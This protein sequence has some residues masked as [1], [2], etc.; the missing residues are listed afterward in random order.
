[1]VST[2][3]YNG[4]GQRM[5][6]T[7]EGVTT[8]Y[9][10][11]VADGLPEVIIATIGG[12]SMYYVQIQGQVLAQQETGAWAY[13]LPD[14]LGSVRQLVDSEGQV[15]LAQSYDPFGVPFEASGSGES[16]FGYTGEAW[17][18]YNELL[19]LRARYY[20]PMVGRLLSKDIFPG[21]PKSPQSLNG[22]SYV[23]NNPIKHTD[24]SGLIYIDGWGYT[25]DDPA[26]VNGL[27][28]DGNPCMPASPGATLQALSLCPPLYAG[29][30]SWKSRPQCNYVSYSTSPNLVKANL[31][32]RETPP[33]PPN[34]CN[35][36]STSD[37]LPLDAIGWRADLSVGF[38]AAGDINVDVI[39]NVDQQL[40][41][42]GPRGWE[43]I[44][45]DLGVYFSLGGQGATVG[46]GLSTGPLF[47]FNLP[48]NDR[49]AEW[50][51]K[52][53][54]TLYLEAGAEVEAFGSLSQ[55]EYPEGTPW[56]IYIGGGM[57]DEASLYGG[58][59]YAWNITE[60]VVNVARRLSAQ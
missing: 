29:D 21:H 16:D 47:L 6:Q 28:P 8:E 59:G 25:C 42:Y 17:G 48:E 26:V 49:V 5:E 10:L 20:D 11:D 53:G 43:F 46:G 31:V 41:R 22:W 37:G 57:G 24:A 7:A 9:V 38:L 33:F 60:L 30:E 15:A 58:G 45:G 52:A 55:E 13:I 23:G 4:L 34:Y 19:F 51:W 36:P 18:S 14:H 35:M 40:L 12:S 32:I 27:G 2:Y 1:V 3:G 56:G 50:G 44:P 39:Y 54:G